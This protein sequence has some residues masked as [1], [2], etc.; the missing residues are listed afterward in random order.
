MSQAPFE[1]TA[2][3]K[4]GSARSH[5]EAFRTLVL[6]HLATQS[7]AW[8][9]VPPEGPLAFPA[10]AIIAAA[11]L[12]FALLAASLVGRGRL[13]CQLAVPIVFAQLVWTFP[14]AAN[15][16][17]LAFVLLGFCA[18][19]DPASREDERAML[20]SLRWI[21]ALVFIWAGLQKVLHGTYF[22]GEFLAW[23]VAQ[24]TDRWAFVFG[25]LIGPEE[26]ARLGSYAAHPVYSGP[27]RVA[28]PLFVAAS[29]SV[30]IMELA[31]GIGLLVHRARHV[32]GL[33]AIGVVLAIQTAPREFMFALLYTN[34]LLL[35][36]RGGFNE[37]LKW[38]FLALYAALLAALLGAPLGFLVRG[39]GTI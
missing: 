6:A 19:F 10:W 32:C 1:W 13:A 25:F 37:R 34:M 9:I 35:C 18:L 4:D 20:Q 5:L 33:L 28:S 24:G 2:D 31:L 26:L 23:L 16:T 29:N 8:A 3:P 30:W 7:A 14:H 21:A 39:S 11:A 22:R 15:H 17:G 38:F 12:E 36:V 27:Y